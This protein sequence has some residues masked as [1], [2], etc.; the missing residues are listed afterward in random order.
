MNENINHSCKMKI[1]PEETKIPKLIKMMQRKSNIN[2][3]NSIPKKD[4]VK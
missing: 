1:G 3:A 2:K 4:I